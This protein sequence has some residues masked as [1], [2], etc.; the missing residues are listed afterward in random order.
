MKCSRKEARLWIDEL[1]R[2]KFNQVVDE[3]K[4]T[5]TQKEILILKH[6]NGFDNSRIGIELSLCKARISHELSK[7]YDRIA[8]IR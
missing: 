5:P 7:I 1:P 2:T 4:L 6:V 8:N 3:L